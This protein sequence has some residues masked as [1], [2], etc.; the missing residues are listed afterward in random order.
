MRYFHQPYTDYPHISVL[1]NSAFLMTPT[2][3][4]H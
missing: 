4:Y 3:P 2:E 1:I